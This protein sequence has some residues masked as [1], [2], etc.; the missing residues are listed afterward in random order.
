MQTY[1]DIAMCS[2]K[3]PD[4]PDPVPPPQAAISPDLA[5]IKARRNVNGAA[6]TNKQA[7]STM[8]TGAA[9]AGANVGKTTLGG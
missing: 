4:I 5:T 9:G 6:S 8:L 1:E 3:T 2:V 7:L